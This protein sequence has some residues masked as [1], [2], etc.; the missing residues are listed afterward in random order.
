M[1]KLLLF[2]LVLL[3]LLAVGCKDDGPTEPEIP[4]FTGTWL[5]DINGSAFEVTATERDGD[6]SGSGVI[7]FGTERVAI[8]VAGTHAH[9]N[10]SLTISSAGYEDFNFSGN[11]TNENRVSGTLNGS[12]FAD[13]P[14]TLNRQ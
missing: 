6:I 8:T 7:S 12:G 13:E 2:P 3:S 14:V 4:S 5:G 10:L 11:F 1:R 9:P